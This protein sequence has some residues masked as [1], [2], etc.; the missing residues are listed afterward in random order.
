MYNNLVLFLLSL[1][2]HIFRLQVHL[3]A[4]VIFLPLRN[5]LYNKNKI[6][7]ILELNLAQVK[8][9]TF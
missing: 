5:L 7:V 8:H 6:Y 9:K 1:S 4:K 3:I 2:I